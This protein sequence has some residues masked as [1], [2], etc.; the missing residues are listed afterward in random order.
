MRETSGLVSP[1][2]VEPAYG[3]AKSILRPR[4]VQSTVPRPSDRSQARF[5]FAVP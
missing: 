1:R 3:F 4:F 2:P 5:D